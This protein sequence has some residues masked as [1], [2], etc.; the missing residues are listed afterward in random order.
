MS[1][2]IPFLPPVLETINQIVTSKTIPALDEMQ[3]SDVT[4]YL[5]KFAD[6]SLRLAIAETAYRNHKQPHALDLFLS[7]TMPLAERWAA[8]KA[9]NL[10][11]HPSDWQLECFYNGAVSAI[12]KTFHNPFPLR[13]E[14]DAF[15]RFLPYRFACGAIEAY[16]TRYENHRMTTVENLE[17]VTRPD[18]YSNPIE[19]ELIT[20]DLLEKI[21]EYPLLQRS[22]S[23]TLECIRELGPD[24]VLKERH[25]AE[26]RNPER[27][28]KGFAG[29]PMLNPQ[30]IAEARGITPGFVL[31][32]ISTARR[33]LQKAFNGDGRLFATH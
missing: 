4:Q 25:W 15:R 26:Q 19:Q 22:V 18:L 30:T 12:L 28:K 16:F 10:F 32:Q 8:R 27:S 21:S 14:P 3:L 29:R 9:Y 2:A 6:K 11:M 24:V 1:S 17:L 5:F 31:V 33:I 20:R 23:K 13:D 7:A